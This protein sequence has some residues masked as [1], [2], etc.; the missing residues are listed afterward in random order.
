MKNSSTVNVLL[1]VL[2]ASA[3]AS[4]ILCGL[5]ISRSRD[6]RSLQSQ[7]VMAR[8]RQAFYNQLA[9]EVLEYSKKNPSIDPIVDTYLRPKAVNTNKPASK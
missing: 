2:A 3:L 6:L 4:L 5:Y 7:Q 8:Y 1:A 9:N